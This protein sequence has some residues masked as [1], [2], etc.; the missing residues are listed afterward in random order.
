MELKY[1]EPFNN[2]IE[3]AVQWVDADRNLQ[4]QMAKKL[5]R[6]YIALSII[7]LSTSKNR[8]NAI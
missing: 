8:C 2:V 6:P 1:K 7:F 4:N 5:A 3:L